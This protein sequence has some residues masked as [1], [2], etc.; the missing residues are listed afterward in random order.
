MKK[1]KL[2]ETEV[3]KLKHRLIIR[4][5]KPTSKFSTLRHLK[6]GRRFGKR[7]KIVIVI[8]LSR[9]NKLVENDERRK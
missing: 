5:S 2:S 8:P 4:V 6:F 3:E 9:I 7:K 1:N